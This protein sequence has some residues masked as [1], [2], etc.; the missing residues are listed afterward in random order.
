[1]L[2]A[3]RPQFVAIL[4]RLGKV[5]DR[6][7]DADTLDAYWEALRDLPLEAL[8]A[9]AE[10]CIRVAK[11][12]PK[13]RELRENPEG[14]R[15][16]VDTRSPDAGVDAWGATLNRCMLRVVIGRLVRTHQ[17]V[18][19]PRLSAMMAY[20]NRVAAQMREANTSAD[21]WRDMVPGVIAELERLAA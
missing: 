8:R 16:V 13:P 5:F 20:K 1:M 6:T 11:F 3:E 4:G 10:T 17:A 7:L 18:D 15:R 14:E 21:E 19:D 12:F 9:R 2:A